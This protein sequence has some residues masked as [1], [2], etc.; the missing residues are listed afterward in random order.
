[1]TR[2]RR[3]SNDL[4]LKTAREVFLEQGASVSTTA[5]A[6]RAGVSQ[7]VL[8]QRFGTKERLMLEALMPPSNQPW[9]DQVAAGPDEREIDVQLRELAGEISELFERITPAIS[10]LRSAG[11]CVK[12]MFEPGRQPPPLRGH[13]VV[14]Q[15]FETARAAGRIDVDDPAAVAMAFIGA[16]QAQAFLNHISGGAVFP[17]GRDAYLDWLAEFFWR[18]LRPGEAT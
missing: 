17:V 9:Q 3:I 4:I 5:I 7:A 14:T 15:W 2:P 13:L 11:Y 6:E 18:G 16:L 8:F 10:V 1:M 12:E